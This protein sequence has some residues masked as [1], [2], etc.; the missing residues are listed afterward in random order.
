GLSNGMPLRYRIAFK[1]A[2]SIVAKQRSVD[3]SKN[4]EVDLVV[5]GRHDPTVVPRAVPVVESVTALVLADHAMRAGMV[6]PV[7]KQ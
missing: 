3:L 6:S 1:P 5:P 2:S 4:A 7:L